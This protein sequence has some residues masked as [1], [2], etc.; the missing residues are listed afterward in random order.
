ME[1]SLLVIISFPLSV[2]SHCVDK[3]G[4]EYAEGEQWKEGCEHCECSNGIP[5]CKLIPCPLFMPPEGTQCKVRPGTENDCCPQFDCEEGKL[6]CFALNSKT[7]L[8]TSEYAPEPIDLLQT[9]DL[10]QT[11]SANC[12]KSFT[13]YKHILT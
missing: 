7:H 13:G 12:L 1:I 2:E 11:F 8:M 9:L 6:F 4:K 10:Q 3:E 5:S